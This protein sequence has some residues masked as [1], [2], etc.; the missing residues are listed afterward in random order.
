MVVGKISR[1][2]LNPLFRYGIH[3]FSCLLGGRRPELSE[4]IALVVA[5]A[6]AKAVTLPAAVTLAV[7][8]VLTAVV[9]LTIAV[10]L[11]AAIVLNAGN[12]TFTVGLWATT[13]S[14][15]YH[16]PFHG[17]TLPSGTWSGPLIAQKLSSFFL[18]FHYC[19]SLF[20]YHR[21]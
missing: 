16:S 13:H 21:V 1:P 6:L 17:Y 19:Y 4:A 9:V 15:V 5:V 12:D 7:A 11:A 10:T 8:V 3:Y 18:R 2:N 14:Q 20:W